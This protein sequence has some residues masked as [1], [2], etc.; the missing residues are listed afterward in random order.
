MGLSGFVPPIY[1]TQTFEMFLHKD[2]QVSQS[3]YR[4]MPPSTGFVN[5]RIQYFMSAKAYFKSIVM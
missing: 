4:N 1:A 5:Y 3:L 2:D